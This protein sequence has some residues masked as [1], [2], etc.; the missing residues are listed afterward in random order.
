VDT[1]ASAIIDT[2]IVRLAGLVSGLNRRIKVDG[3]RPWVPIDVL[4]TAGCFFA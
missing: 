1:R 3:L 4:A 2:Q